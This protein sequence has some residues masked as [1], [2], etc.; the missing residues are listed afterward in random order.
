MN[1]TQLLTLLN[2]FQSQGRDEGDAQFFYQGNN[3]AI[4]NA[5]LDNMPLVIKALEECQA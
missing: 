4:I 2:T 1:S 3:Y 5:L